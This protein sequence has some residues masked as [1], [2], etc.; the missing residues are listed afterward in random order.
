MM[1]KSDVIL[2]TEKVRYSA[3]RDSEDHL[4]HYLK[5]ANLVSGWSWEKHFYTVPKAACCGKWCNLQP[6]SLF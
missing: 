2:T 4:N 5:T 1:Y 6:H 3:G